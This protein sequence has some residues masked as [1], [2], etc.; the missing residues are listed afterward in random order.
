MAAERLSM[1]KIK[2]VLRLAAAG[3]SNRVI[4]RSVR[5]ARSTAREYLQRAGAS[6]SELAAAGGS[7]GDGAGGA[8]VPLPPAPSN[9]SGRCRT[10]A[11]SS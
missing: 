6:R 7:D 9:H 5:I 2:E 4:A 1:R 3:Q 11:G 10:G 8:A